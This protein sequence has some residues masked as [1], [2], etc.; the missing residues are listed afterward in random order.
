[1]TEYLIEVTASAGLIVSRDM[2][3]F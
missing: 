3:I 2:L 1:V